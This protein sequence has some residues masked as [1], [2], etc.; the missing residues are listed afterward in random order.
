MP[1]YIYQ[2][3]LLHAHYDNH[4][5]LLEWHVFRVTNY[6]TVLSQ[7]YYNSVQYTAHALHVR[8][9]YLRIASK[10]PQATQGKAKPECQVKDMV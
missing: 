5:Q 6:S 8:M 9:W 7:A 3:N 4:L 2:Q 1:I 10:V